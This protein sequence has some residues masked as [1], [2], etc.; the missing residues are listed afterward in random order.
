MQKLRDTET[1]QF[2]RFRVQSSTMFKADVLRTTCKTCSV[3]CSV[4]TIPS[5]L[6]ASFSCLFIYVAASGPSCGTWNLHWLCGSFVVVVPGL[7]SCGT[8]LPESGQHGLS[9]SVACGIL[10]SR[11]G[12]KPVS[13]ELQGGFLT[14]GQSGKS[15]LRLFMFGAS[16]STSLSFLRIQ[17]IYKSDGLRATNLTSLVR[18]PTGLLS[19]KSLR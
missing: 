14:T 6:P 18:P 13:P 1:S 2:R 8:Q 9:C 12:I 19:L 10:V 4:Q 17:S 16:V 15:L 11:P 3:F 7:Y 5:S